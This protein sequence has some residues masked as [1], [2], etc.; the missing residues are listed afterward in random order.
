MSSSFKTISSGFSKIIDFELF[1]I[2]ELIHELIF[3]SIMKT[4]NENWVDQFPESRL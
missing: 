3:S 2:S 1:K 4:E